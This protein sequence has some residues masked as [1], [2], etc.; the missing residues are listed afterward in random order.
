[1]QHTPGRTSDSSGLSFLQRQVDLARVGSYLVAALASGVVG[2]VLARIAMRFAA[3]IIGQDPGFSITGSVGVVLLFVIA[4]LAIALLCLVGGRFLPQNTARL[5]TVVS[6]LLSVLMLP[7]FVLVARGDAPAASMALI[8]LLVLSFVPIPIGMGV[9]LV[10]GVRWLNKNLGRNGRPTL[11]I[12]WLAL[13]LLLGFLLL[14]NVVG[15]ANQHVRHPAL[16]SNWLGRVGDHM[17]MA[18]VR[19][20]AFLIALLFTLLWGVL[21][22]LVVWNDTRA[23]R[24]PL[25][26]LLLLALPTLTLMTIESLPGVLGVFTGWSLS[27]QLAQAAG[28]GILLVLIAIAE[29]HRSLPRWV[30]I[31][32]ALAWLF[33]ALWLLL[34]RFQEIR[35]SE[36]IVWG[37]LATASLLLV[38]ARSGEAGWQTGTTLLLLFV[39]CWL[40][41]WLA[42]LTVP[43][44]ALR[45]YTG[46]QSALS[47]P[48]S[49][50]PWLL[51][52]TGIWVASRSDAG[53][54]ETL[55]AKAIPT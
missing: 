22:A 35:G 16:M 17:N 14:L 7:F 52:P 12:G 2:G 51:L 55:A 27:V 29:P 11:G 48:L 21:A 24:A 46:Y 50:V 3:L 19:D 32:T 54:V 31:L 30:W 13:L 47:A 5:A 10:Y 6:L 15:M 45:G 8:V 43:Q 23:H 1:M 37:V 41:A 4:A 38:F 28:L 42:A 25:R 39:L 34:P 44:L 40:G 18:V 33:G 49:W 20:R 26:S 53:H 36:W 9:A